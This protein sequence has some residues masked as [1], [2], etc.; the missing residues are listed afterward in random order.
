MRKIGILIMSVLVLTGCVQ[1]VNLTNEE[2][3][4]IASYAAY[5]TLQ[6]DKNYSKR[7]VDTSQDLTATT[8]VSIEEQANDTGDGVSNETLTKEVTE[9]TTT[10]Q[11]A[12]QDAEAAKAQP[13]DIASVLNL[14]G[15]KI[16][17]EGY[18][19]SKQYKEVN[20]GTAYIA[21]SLENNKF[22]VLKFTV[23]NTTDETRVCDILSLSPTLRVS[24]NGGEAVN[25]FASLLSNDM[26]TLFDE[27][28]AQASKDMI[29][30]VE[31]PQ[32][33]DDNISSISLE[34]VLKGNTSTIE[35]NE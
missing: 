25:I 16:T 20:E 29:L 27:I 26:S 3:D 18:E 11:E 34:V 22:L 7:L 24:I 23:E 21:N 31:V 17:Y 9:Q 6:H 5:V 12:D 10:T 30:L 19:H 13:L 8:E 2:S 14:E 4:T 32:E 1:Q 33:Y 28:E 15:F 35:L